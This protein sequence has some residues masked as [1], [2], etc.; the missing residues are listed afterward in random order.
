MELLAGEREERAVARIRDML[1]HF[2]LVPAEGLVDYNEAASI[3]RACRRRGE[4]LR[5]L[6]DCVIA[7]VAIRVEA[8][9]LHLDRDF[10][11]IARHTTLELVS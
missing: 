4:A 6:L 1:A 2:E 11:A 9:V 10:D 7:A 3:Y 8:S 5:S